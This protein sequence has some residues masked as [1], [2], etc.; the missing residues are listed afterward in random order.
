MEKINRED[1]LELTRRMTLKRNCFDRIAGAYMDEEGFVDGTF[2]RHFQKLTARERQDNLDIAKAI[3]FS[4]TNVQLR[5]YV[6]SETDRRQGSLWQLLMA[7]K[8]CEL[9]NDAML[10]VFYEE[11]GSRYRANGSYAVMFF[12]GSYDVPLKA[13]DK[14]SLWESEEVFR[15]LICAFCPV[16]GDYKPGK[17]DCGFLFPAFRDRSSDIHRI[18]VFREDG[19]FVGGCKKSCV[20]G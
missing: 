16:S 14:A 4:D 18:D 1:M 5:E 12:H 3:P 2:N 13:G 6:I 8:E 9:K 15:F 11:F 7:L 10:D 17:P 19:R 20:Y